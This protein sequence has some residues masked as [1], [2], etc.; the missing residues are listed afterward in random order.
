MNFLERTQRS[1]LFLKNVPVAF[2]KILFFFTFLS[3]PF[4]NPIIANDKRW[5]CG[6]QNTITALSNERLFKKRKGKK[7]RNFFSFYL[8]SIFSWIAD[9]CSV[10]CKYEN[11]IKY[12]TS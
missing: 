9:W 5:R 7:P 2:L 4:Q 6:E 10:Q 3:P 1:T 12:K 11:L 8:E